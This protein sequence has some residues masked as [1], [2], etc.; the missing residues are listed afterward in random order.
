MLQTTIPYTTFRGSSSS[1]H[2]TLRVPGNADG[3]PCPVVVNVHGGFWKTKWSLQNLDT[4]TLLGAFAG[5]ATW[6][7]EY[8]RVDQADPPASPEG[9]GFPHSCL[10]V[11]AAVNALADGTVPPALRAQL[12]L[13]RVYL[14]GHSAGG[15]IA[16][17]LAMVSRL[18][19]DKRSELATA[20]DAAVGAEAAQALRAGVSPG[21]LIRGAIGLASVTCLTDAL[22]DG[23]SDNHDAAINFLWR[24]GASAGAGDGATAAPWLACACPC[25]LLG[26]LLADEASGAAGTAGTAGTAATDTDT[27]A[28]TAAAGDAPAPPPPLRLLLL[29]G[30]SDEDVPATQSVTLAAAAW[31]ASAPASSTAAPAAAAAAAAARVSVQLALVEGADHYEVAGLCDTATPGAPAERWE[32]MAAALGAFVREA[33]DDDDEA[34]APAALAKL[35]VASEAEARALCAK[36]RPHI[37]AARSVAA[38][39]EKGAADAAAAAPADAELARGLRRWFA[40]NGTTPPEG[41]LL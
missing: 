13:T 29:S 19:P 10:D 3:T 25:M 8:T 39:Q 7:V 17:W 37:C 11:L 26:S 35:C 15:H 5:C 2:A 33:E 41:V 24:A 27:V 20:L 40:W 36:A 14:C 6:D 18:R 16:L 12:D 4:S 23:L 1:H 38:L 21:V 34:P 32:A 28:A 22:A 30:L 9:G 31:S